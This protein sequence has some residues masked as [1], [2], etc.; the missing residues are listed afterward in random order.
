M[1]VQDVLKLKVTA[2]NTGGAFDGIFNSV[3]FQP[4]RENNQLLLNNCNSGTD[5]RFSVKYYAT[6]GFEYP[7]GN[8]SINVVYTATQM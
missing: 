4:I 3:S 6:P 1:P 5:R 7:G 8:Y 2:N